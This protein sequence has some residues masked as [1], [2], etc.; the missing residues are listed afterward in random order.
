M[1]CRRSTSGNNQTSFRDMSELHNRIFN[2]ALIAHS[3]RTDLDPHRP[4][5][6]LNRA[7]LASSSRIDVTQD[8]CSRQTRFNRFEKANPFSGHAEVELSKSSYVA[9]RTCAALDIAGTN[10]IRHLSEHDRYVACPVEQWVHR[11]S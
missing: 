2:I 3:S 9:A 4:G 6:G 7:K 8:H 1:R 10:W 5:C 11:G